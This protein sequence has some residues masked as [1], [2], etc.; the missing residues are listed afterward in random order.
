VDDDKFKNGEGKVVGRKPF[1]RVV[2]GFDE[3]QQRL[4]LKEKGVPEFKEVGQAGLGQVAAVAGGGVVNLEPPAEN[5]SIRKHVDKG[6]EKEM[7]W[8]DLYKKL[9]GIAH[10]IEQSAIKISGLK[11]WVGMSRFLEDNNACPTLCRDWQGRGLVVPI[12]AKQT[13]KIF[14]L[15][16]FEEDIDRDQLFQAWNRITDQE[17]RELLKKAALACDLPTEGLKV[18]QAESSQPKK[19]V[20]PKEFVVKS[21]AVSPRVNVQGNGLRSH[22]LQVLLDDSG[23]REALEEAVARAAQGKRPTASTFIELLMARQEIL[24]KSGK[25]YL[26]KET[27]LDEL[28]DGALGK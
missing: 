28:L 27:N 2:V 21:G 15:R 16:L 24:R 1:P 9:Y 11:V 3:F 25:E 12:G 26:L 7:Q 18:L 23:V 8:V 13:T 19:E 14:L 17:R 10:D 20:R 22:L 4:L 6:G 5:V